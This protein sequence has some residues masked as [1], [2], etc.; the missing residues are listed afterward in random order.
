VARW[1]LAHDRG[2]FVRARAEYERLASAAFSKVEGH[3][4][5]DLLHIPYTHLIMRCAN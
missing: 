4:R 3:L 2:K 5:H 1:M